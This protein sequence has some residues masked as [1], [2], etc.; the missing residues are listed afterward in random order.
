MSQ[1]S[2]CIVDDDSDIR[3]LLK[4]ILEDGQWYEIEEFSHPN[5]LKRRLSKKKP[6]LMILDIMFADSTI[7]D[8]LKYRASNEEI[9]DIPVI[10]LSGL[11]NKKIVSQVQTY[12]I[13]DYH[14]KPFRPNVITTSV[15]RIL[16]DSDPKDFMFENERLLDVGVP[17]TFTDVSEVQILA[18][19]G[20]KLEA[21]KEYNIACKELLAFEIQT[22]KM[23]A[24]ENSS[25]EPSS[26]E[27]VTKFKIRGTNGKFLSQVRAGKL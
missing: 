11:K 10:V 20:V 3:N 25:L 13:S 1:K 19:S 14:L 22:D 21:G 6:N 8:F 12:N 2:I 7:I 24:Q 26:G 5:D 9:K 17:I 16:K 18:R 27:F 23:L 4:R 15:K